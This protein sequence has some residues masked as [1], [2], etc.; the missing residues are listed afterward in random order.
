MRTRLLLGL[1]A[2]TMGL[3]ACG[4][5]AGPG[6]D[7][8][9]S[10]PVGTG[11]TVVTE[12]SASTVTVAVDVAGTGGTGAGGTSPAT[13]TSGTTGRTG[14][15]VGG[16]AAAV[17]GTGTVAVE[18]EEVD[19]VFIEG[20]EIGLRFEQADGTVIAGTLWSDFVIS[21]GDPTMDAWYDSVLQQPVPA[22]P[23]VVWAQANVG[24]GPG[25]VVP[26]V[27]GN[28]PCR[29]DVEVPPGTTVR[30]RVG[31]TDP[32]TCLTLIEV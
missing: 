1:T 32:A 28:L 2:L 23:V 9:P 24:I 10:V 21:Q 22:G 5:G 27:D 18:L 17:E 7:A 6:A 30:V 19:G 16:G 4:S 26:D 14:G 13:A 8:G 11:P 12:Q 31:F 15:S 25:P 20:F 29:L 3:G